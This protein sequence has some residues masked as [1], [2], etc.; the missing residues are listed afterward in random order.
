MEIVPLKCPNCNAL[1]YIEKNL[2]R[3]Y[4]SHCGSQILISDP[5][6]K[7]VTY[8]K[9]DAARIREAETREKIRQRELDIQERQLN[10]E[11]N[12]LIVKTILIAVAIIAVAAII[13]YVLHLAHSDSQFGK[14]LGFIIL[15][16]VATTALAFIVYFKN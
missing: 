7:K 4:C 8:T 5:N 14:G 3:C 13:M 15:F 2:D 12:Q 16:T 10:R 11:K 1:I 6:N 9:I